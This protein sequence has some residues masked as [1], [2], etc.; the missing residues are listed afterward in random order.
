MLES[1]LESELGLPVFPLRYRVVQIE[2]TRPVARIAE[3]F[4]R[5]TEIPDRGLRI[6]EENLLQKR[7]LGVRVEET[8]LETDLKARVGRSARAC[9][10]VVRL[11]RRK[12]RSKPRGLRIQFRTGRGCLRRRR[13]FRRC[14]WPLLS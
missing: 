6:A 5:R 14:R 9:R 11:V 1:A 7:R 12:R 4:G 8:E 13:P 3:R 2:Q 10:E